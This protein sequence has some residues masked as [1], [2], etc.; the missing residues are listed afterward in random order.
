MRAGLRVRLSDAGR[1]PLL[2]SRL[3]GSRAA[4]VRALPARPFAHW[5][6]SRPW[7][8][9]ARLGQ[10]LCPDHRAT[11]G[12]TPV[13][14]SPLASHSK[15]LPFSLNWIDVRSHP[16]QHRQIQPR[17]RDM[18]ALSWLG[19]SAC[20]I[21]AS[22]AGGKEPFRF[23]P[24]GPP[25]KPVARFRKPPVGVCGRGHAV[26][27]VAEI[28]RLVSQGRTPLRLPSVAACRRVVPR[29]GSLRS[30]LVAR[31]A[32]RFSGCDTGCQPPIFRIE[33][34]LTSG[35]MPPIFPTCRFLMNMR[36]HPLTTAEGRS[37]ITTPLL[38][39]LD[40]ATGRKSG[41]IQL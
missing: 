6:V 28:D 33:G 38:R 24:S 1:F 29:H 31:C 32:R 40:R 14:A 37:R 41:A 39:H 17:L 22:R 13:A 35:P 20:R 12:V 9:K 26:A 30:P 10:P 11:F 25:A 5:G 23:P 21:S 7:L 27:V 19:P 3:C 34:G 16:T 2:L 18:S 8:P 4:G 15:W 36:H